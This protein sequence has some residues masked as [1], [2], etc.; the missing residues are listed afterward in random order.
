QHLALDVRKDRLIR[1]VVVVIVGAVRFALQLGELFAA[2]DIEIPAYGLRAVEAVERYGRLAGAAPL[3]GDEDDAVGRTGPVDGLRRRILEDLDGGNVIRVDVIDAADGHAVGNDDGRVAGGERPAAADQDVGRAARGCIRHR[4]VNARGLA[5]QHL[6][7][8]VGR[9]FVDTFGIDRH[10]RADDIALFLYAV[11]DDHHLVHVNGRRGLQL[12]IHAR[13]A[14]DRHFPG[15]HAHERKDQYGGVRRYGKTVAPVGVR[16]RPVGGAFFQN[17]YPGQGLAVA[18][19]HVPAE[20][21]HLS[22]QRIAEKQRHEKNQ[23]IL[24][25]NLLFFT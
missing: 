4:D 5:A 10:D 11:T 9:H 18:V 12:H 19:R 25:H 2:V 14:V 1:Q 24:P 13:A 8:V 17:G 22:G 6:A 15:F 23:I 7:Q 20:G 3:G 16:H 21:P